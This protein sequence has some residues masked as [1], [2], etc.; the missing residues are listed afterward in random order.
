MYSGV[1][2]PVFYSTNFSTIVGTVTEKKSSIIYKR[3]IGGKGPGEEASCWEMINDIQI[4]WGA[5][6]CT[7]VRTYEYR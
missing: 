3:K 5:N 4:L 1:T 7:Y 6:V 2:R